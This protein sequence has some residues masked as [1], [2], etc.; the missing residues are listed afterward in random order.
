MKKICSFFIVLGLMIV[1]VFS[2]SACSGDAKPTSYYINGEGNLIAVLDNGKEDDLGKWG[3][4]VIS[5]FKKVTISEDGYYVIDGI[6]T[7]ISLGRKIWVNPE[8]KL[9]IESSGKYVKSQPWNIEKHCWDVSFSGTTVT[10]TC[11]R[12]GVQARSSIDIT[13]Y[14]KYNQA[15]ILFDFN[16]WKNKK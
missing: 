2:L 6:K 14:Y 4:S 13:P 9:I 7:R 15:Y 8:G 16:F 3:E 10:A 1:M 11:K 12:N 5:S